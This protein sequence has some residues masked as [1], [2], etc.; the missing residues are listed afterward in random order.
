M[1]GQLAAIEQALDSDSTDG[2]AVIS[3]VVPCYNESQ[4]ILLLYQRL[5]E[6]AETWEEPFEVI[7][8][9]DGSSDDTW[10]KLCDV[11]SRDSRWKLVRFSRNFGHQAAVTAGIRHCSGDAVVVIDA[12]LQDPPEE[13]GRFIDT[14]KKG[15]E[16]VYAIRTKRKEGMVLRFCYQIFYR[17]LGRMTK[18]QIP[19]DAGDFCLMDRRVVDVL[20]AMPEQNR[21]VRGLRAWSG[22]RQIGLRYERAA[23]AAGQPLYTLRDLLRLALDGI[24]SFSTA[25]LRLATLFG[26]LVSGAA[27][28]GIAFSILQRIF[29]EW[30]TRI[31]FPFVPGYATI[32]ISM[33][34]LGGVQL[35][36]LGIIGEYIGRIYDEVKRRPLWIVRESLGTD[37]PATRP[38]Q[39]RRSEEPN[40]DIMEQ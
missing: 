19:Y 8:V 18:I 40:S 35:V 13:I 36:S 12:D 10:Q 39:Q 1:F 22:F 20:N 33:L 21:F 28:L 4:V 16:V 37:D 27:F 29:S 11:R 17:I 14:W 31:G 30:F 38:S 2:K 23:R 26:F 5:T 7:A 9:D 6:A 24:F 25:P 15:Y 3:V 32:I 34:F